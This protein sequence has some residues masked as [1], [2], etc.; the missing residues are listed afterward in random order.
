[1]KCGWRRRASARS[2]S[3]RICRTRVTSIESWASAALRPAR[4]VLAV[5]SLVHDLEQAGLDLGLI[6]VADRP[7]AAVA[8]RPVLEGELAQHV[9]DL[10]AER[11]ALLSS[12]SSRR[13]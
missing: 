11:L 10:A 13:W 12:F 5:E 8:Q 3:S 7:R 1:M 6:A 9:E 2:M 4:E